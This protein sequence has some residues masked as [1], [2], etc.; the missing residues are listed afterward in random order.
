MPPKEATW[1]FKIVHSHSEF[2][3]YYLSA[4]SEQ[5]MKV[6]EPRCEKNRSSEFTTWSDTNEAVPLQKMASGFKFW[7]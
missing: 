4:S 3:T 2:R 7:I 6:F 1:V 5:E